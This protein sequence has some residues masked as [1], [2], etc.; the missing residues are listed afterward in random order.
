[1]QNYNMIIIIL[2]YLSKDPFILFV[3]QDIFML[4]MFC[5]VILSYFV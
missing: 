4:I 2:D 5:L 3:K 1:M